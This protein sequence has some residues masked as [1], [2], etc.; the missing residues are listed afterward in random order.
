MKR[1][2]YFLGLL[3]GLMFLG[4]CTKYS[5]KSMDKKVVGTWTF[6]KVKNKPGLLK[7]SV[8]ITKNFKNWEYT[9]DAGGRVTAYNT[10]TNESEIGRWQMEEYVDVYYDED[11]TTSTTSEYVL[12]FN[13]RDSRG[14][15]YYYVWNVGSITAKRL[16]ASEYF[17]NERTSYVLARKN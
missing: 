6:E 3:A 12:R 13:L 5:F 4:S 1:L 16:R 2:V 7:S 11:G 17:G 10:A 8:D 14:E 9:F 15:D